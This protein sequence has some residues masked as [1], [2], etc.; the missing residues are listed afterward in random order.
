[1]NYL[2][3][4]YKNLAESLQEQ[5]NQLEN[6]LEY[7]K[8]RTQHVDVH[9]VEDTRE[10]A[11]ILHGV[12]VTKKGNPAGKGAAKERSVSFY[13][14]Q[15][16]K[17]IQNYPGHQESD[18]WDIISNA[19]RPTVEGNPIYANLRGKGPALEVDRREIFPGQERGL[20]RKGHHEKGRGKKAA[21]K[22]EAIRKAGQQN[23]SMTYLQ[24]LLAEADQTDPFTDAS[25]M[26]PEMIRA[27]ANQYS[28]IRTPDEIIRQTPGGLGDMTDQE[29]EE[30]DRARAAELAGAIGRREAEE[31]RKRKEKEARKADGE[32]FRREMENYRKTKK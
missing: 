16:F 15:A 18:A 31:E 24:R 27:V 10:D 8:S 28:N 2:T 5:V 32:S 21:K 9:D 29:W 19:G 17:T 14:S 7:K 26:T 11:P 22:R 6:L 20:R 23:E 3:N 30:Y 1:M 4:Y 25:R 13:P 12:V